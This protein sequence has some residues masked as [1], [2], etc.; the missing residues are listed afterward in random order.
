MCQVS[1]PPRHHRHPLHHDWAV[2]ECP[3]DLQFGLD[4]YG[5]QMKI[6]ELGRREEEKRG[7]KNGKV[8][9]CSGNRVFEAEK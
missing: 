3:N 6:C 8:K 5:V 1:H 7:W 9:K 2:D 4:D